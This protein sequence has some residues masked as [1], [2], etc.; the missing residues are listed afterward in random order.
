MLTKHYTAFSR[1]VREG[2]V[3]EKMAR[4]ND[5]IMNSK[6]EITGSRVSRKKIRVN[7]EEVEILYG[8]IEKLESKE[9][10]L[11]TELEQGGDEYL[12]RDLWER[13]VTSGKRKVETPSNTEEERPVDE[14]EVRSTK[15]QK[16]MTEYLVDLVDQ[17]PQRVEEDI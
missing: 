6:R 8:D 2:V 3:I 4:E 15:R 12:D 13:I 10:K 17:Q 1:Q 14:T 16:L 5:L 11:L 9:R 7:G